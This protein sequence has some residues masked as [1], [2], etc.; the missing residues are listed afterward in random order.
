MSSKV[1]LKNGVQEDL[2]SVEAV[3]FDLYWL[4]VHHPDAFRQL[5]NLCHG[6]S[7]TVTP[8]AVADM[9]AKNFLQDESTPYDDVRDIVVSGTE[10]EGNTW[11]RCNPLQNPD[12]GGR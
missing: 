2:Q 12:D 3:T 1:S 6:R 8:Q 7:A 5:C 4:Q 9:S 10:Q 11:K